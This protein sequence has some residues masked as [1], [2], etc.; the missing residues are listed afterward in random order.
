MSHNWMASIKSINNDL[1]CVILRLNCWS[2]FDRC[3]FLFLFSS[4]SS[5]LFLSLLL[6]SLHLWYF[7]FSDFCLSTPVRTLN[8]RDEGPLGQ[9]QIHKFWG[10]QDSGD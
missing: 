7:V 3:W 1:D 5:S 9:F 4:S 8:F 2:Y 10:H 6:Y